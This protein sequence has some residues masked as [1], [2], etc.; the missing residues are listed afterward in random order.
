M[1]MYKQQ[2]NSISTKYEKNIL[3]PGIKIFS[4][5][6]GVMDTGDHPLL[7]YISENFRKNFKFPSGARQLIRE[8]IT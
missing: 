3:H 8:K 5:I 2:A 1:S 6:A 4:F 7:R